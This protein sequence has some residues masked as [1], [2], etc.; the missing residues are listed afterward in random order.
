MLSEGWR[1]VR[2]RTL[3]P[4]IAPPRPDKIWYL[5]QTRLFDRLS[6][7]DLRRL[8]Q[9]SEMHEYPRGQVILSPAH[10]P[11]RI[12]FV[13]TGRVKM[14]AYSAD[15]KEQILALLDPGDLF[16]ELAHTEPPGAVRVEAFSHSI[17]C[18]LHR[19]SF[20]DVIKKTPEVA[21]QVIRV[22]ARRLRGAEKEIEDLALRDVP[23][24]VA[25]LLLRMGEEYGERHDRGI[26]LAFRLTHQN[27]AHMVGS[28]RETVTTIMSRFR[29]DGLIA[30]DHR[31]VII[32]DRE[33]LSAV[34]SLRRT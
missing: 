4:I 5:R 33:R 2:R 32:L 15:G 22:L 26:R 6:E 19:A 7:V 28:T 31:T 34:A 18:T 27:L 9:V 8:A 25:S 1:F 21:L 3:P 30:V 10:D 20:E 14:S 29:D 13:K 12:Y 23:G 16:G 11:D 24:R 17:V